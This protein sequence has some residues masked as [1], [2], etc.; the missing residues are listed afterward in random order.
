[1]LRKCAAVVAVVLCLAN[2]NATRAEPGP[3]VNWLIAEQA[4]LFDIGLS[5]LDIAAYRWSSPW[6]T[7]N[8]EMV[9][10]Y[11]NSPIYVLVDVGD[12]VTD[13]AKT[14]CRSILGHLSNQANVN[15]ETGSLV[16]HR[17]S[18]SGFTRNA[19]GSHLQ[20]WS[21]VTRK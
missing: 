2:V 6:W 10:Q 15:P 9:A 8:K 19:Q 20:T 12:L 5:R 3:V 4:S 7:F 11:G 13:M 21:D 17:L 16:Y 1:M 18:N 14:A